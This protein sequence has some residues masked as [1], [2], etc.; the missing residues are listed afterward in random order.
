[1]PQIPFVGA[2]YQERSASLDCQACI[3]LFP[4]LGESGTAK[5]VKALYGTPGTRPLV[6]AAD[7]VVRGMLNPTTGTDAVVVVG[8]TVYRMNKAFV[9]TPIGS[10]DSLSTPVSIDDNG[11]QAV[12]VTGPNGYVVDLSANTVNQI[13]DPAFYGADRVDFLN[14]YAIFNRPGTNQFYLSGANEIT[15]DPLDFATAESNYEPII[16]FIVSHDEIIFFKQTVTEIWRASGNADFPF[17]RDTNAAIEQGCAAR[18]SVASLDN[19]VFWLGQNADGGGIIYRMN[20]YTPQRVSTDAIEFAIASYGK[21]SDATAYAYQQEG[22]TF[23][24]ITF[25]TGGATWDFDVATQMWHQRA[26]LNPSTGNLERHRSNCHMYFNGKHVVGDYKTGDLY[27]LDLDY[28]MDGASDPL[29]AIRAASHIAESD[30]G[31]I[32]HNRLQIDIESGVGLSTG[33]GATPL[34]MLDWSDDGGKNWSNQ[35]RASVGHIGSF[36]TRL[37]WNRLGRARNRVYRITISDPV[38]RVIIGASLN[39][40]E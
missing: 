16:N 38:K 37:R 35:H 20:G 23:Y 31:W 28:F 6:S 36:L 11:L 26:Y 15:F 33:Q 27:T 14:T 29:P 22:H 34:A 1:M 7:G 18:D 9:L 40:K 24:Q 39:P 2:S 17:A 19:T 32:V 5:A 30:Y 13:A 3:N 21:I 25:P 8:S 10:I 4:V 12:I